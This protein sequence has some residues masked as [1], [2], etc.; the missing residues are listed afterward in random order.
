MPRVPLSRSALATVDGASIGQ[1]VAI[2][3]FIAQHTGLLGANPVEASQILSFGE[4]IKELREAYA[5]LVPWGTEPSAAAADA[6]FDSVEAADATG[7]AD[8]SKRDARLL[9]WYMGR[10]ERLVG[11]GFA[12]GGKLSLADILLFNAFADSL[13]PEQALGELPAHRREP[14]GSL[15]RTQAALAKH[16]RLAKIVAGVAALPNIQK[17]L[18]TRGKQGF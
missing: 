1:S 7:P 3:H 2:N 17:W 6:V 12:V 16:P 14:F 15:A 9:L 4:H 18:S 11:D 13:T 8:S 5:K 10:L